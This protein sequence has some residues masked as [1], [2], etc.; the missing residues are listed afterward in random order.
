MRM[1]N[2]SKLASLLTENYGLVKVMGRGARRPRSTLGAALEPLTLIDCTY[3]H[4]DVR[5]IQTISSAEIIKPYLRLKDDLYLL[6]IASCMVEISQTHTAVGDVSS[7]TFNLVVPA[8]DSL[9]ASESR[10]A[11]KHLWRYVLQLLSDAGYRPALDACVKCGN[12]PKGTKVF[13]S[14]ADGGMLCSCTEPDNRYGFRVSAGTLMVMN[15]LLDATDEELPRLSIGKRQ[16]NEVEKA[17]LQF[18]AYNSGSTRTPRSLAF[19]RKMEMG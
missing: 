19:M 13:F 8:L 18:L 3:Y 4:K 7:G 11:D 15:S 16:R 10:H 9:E 14:Y 5:E 2:S 1:S 17:V 6:A 12:K